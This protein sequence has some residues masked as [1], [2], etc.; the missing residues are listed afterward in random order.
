MHGAVLTG[1]PRKQGTTALLADNFVEGAQ[2]AGHAI[3]RFDAA[4][5]DV[6]PCRG[7]N[8]CQRGESPCVLGDDMQQ[9]SPEL[10]RA[11]WSSLSRPSTTTA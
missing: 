3:V 4:F 10:T 8:A 1:S 7:C 11:T 9:P 6:H 5:R 2:R